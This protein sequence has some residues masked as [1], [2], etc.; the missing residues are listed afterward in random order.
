VEEKAQGPV[1]SDK[2]RSLA[3]LVF[4]K[5]TWSNPSGFSHSTTRGCIT[6]SK[7]TTKKET[8]EPTVITPLHLD[9]YQIIRRRDGEK[10]FGYKPAMLDAKIRDGEV[11]TPMAL[12]E[13]GR[14]TGW[15][16]QQIMDH[17]AKRLEITLKRKAAADAKELAEARIVKEVLKRNPTAS[18]TKTRRLRRLME[19]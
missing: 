9:P 5:P 6:L 17:Q 16:G 10:Y 19:A 15:T 8:N 12:S 4:F 7:T 18:K 2:G 13:N 1:E 14:A 3:E 11:P